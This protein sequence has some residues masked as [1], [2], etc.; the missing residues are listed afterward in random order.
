MGFDHSM[1]VQ[2][3]SLHGGCKGYVFKPNWRD[4]DGL[5]DSAHI[6]DSHTTKWDAQRAGE[7]SSC[8][9]VVDEMYMRR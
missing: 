9:I 2:V 6:A 3:N 5:D 4:R 7:V 8:E 1:L